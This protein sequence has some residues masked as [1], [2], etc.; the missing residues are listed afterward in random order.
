MSLANLYAEHYQAVHALAR[1]RLGDAA[2]A[3]DVAADTFLLLAS[4]PGPHTRGGHAGE[5]RAFVLGVCANLVRRARRAGARRSVVLAQYGAE[6]ETAADGVERAATQRE[7]LSRLTSA[8]DSLPDEQQTALLLSSVEGHSAAEIAVV[9]GVPEATVRT[10]LFHARRKLRDALTDHPAPPRYGQRA[11]GVALALALALTFVVASGGARAAAARLDEACHWIL[12]VLHLGGHASLPPA[13]SVPLAERAPA[14][15][16]PG[17]RSPRSSPGS[18]AIEALPAAT[19]AVRMVPPAASTVVTAAPP[20]P[21]PERRALYLRAHQAQFV[22]HDYAAALRA[23]DAY[24]AAGGGRFAMEARYNRAIA[25]AH[26]GR[27]REARSALEPLA[28]GTAGGYRR[29]DARRLLE[30]LPE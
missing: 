22:T 6:A 12:Q 9:C 10:R 2:Q 1:R 16:R 17:E 11:L 20:A 21:D 14:E 4:K 8:F 13:S 7:L 18:A 28:G 3:D 24:L 15:P 27:A 26:L 30:V 29:D 25:L 23:W 5:I 19:V